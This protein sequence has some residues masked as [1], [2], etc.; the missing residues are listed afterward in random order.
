MRYVLLLTFSLAA[1]GQ[2]GPYKILKTVKVGGAGGFDYVTADSVARK[3]YVSRSGA[4]ARVTVFDLD[5][6]APAGEIPGVSSHGVVVS[7]KT[8]HGFASSKPVVMFD[9]KTLAP[10]KNIDVEGNPDGMLYDAVNDRVYVLSHREPHVTVLNA[11]DGA[12]VG[13]ANIGGAPEQA[14]SDG[15]GHIY[16]DVEDKANVAVL[17]AKT[18]MVTAHYDV[19]GK[20]DVCAGL[21]LDVKNNVLFAACRNPQNMVML[22]ATD[23]KVLTTLPLGAGTDGAVS[24]RRPWKRLVHRAMAHSPLLKRTAR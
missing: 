17:D 5:T 6:L 8:G 13:T 16:I 23:G 10:I 12:I 22:S 18:L 1:F 15:K 2:E 19:T 11:A 21:A 7:A 14:A 24:I 9:S 4:G 20:G 3:L